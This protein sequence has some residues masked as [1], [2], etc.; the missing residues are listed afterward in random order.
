MQHFYD[1]YP[2]QQ[3]DRPWLVIGKGPT[4]DRRGEFDLGQYRLL[5]I[6]HVPRDLPVEVSH[7]IDIDVIVDCGDAIE[8]NARFVVLPWMPHV[9][10]AVGNTTLAQYCQDIPVLRRMDAEGRV[11]WYD[12]VTAPV[13]H[14]G[15]RSVDAT[16][17]SAEAA[18]SLLANSGAKKIRTLGVDGGDAYSGAFD[19]LR[20][21]TRLNNGHTSYDLQ[22]AGI[23]KTIF[24]TGIDFSPITELSP[25]KIYVGAEV[26]QRLAV[27]VLDYSIRRHAS[28]ST[29]LVSLHECGIQFKLP[30]KLENRPRTPFSFHRFAIPGLNGFKGK[31]IY[32]DSDMM[33]FQDIRKLWSMPFNGADLLAVGAVDDPSRR[34]QFSV[35]LLNCET[36]KW[37]IPEIVERLDRGELTYETLMYDM[38][39]AP[40]ISPSISR[41]W[42]SLEHYEKGNTCLLHYTDMKRQPW[43]WTRN[44]LGYLWIDYLRD[45]IRDG[46]ISRE[47]VQEDIERGWV[48]PSLLWEMDRG[49]DL[50]SYPG[51]LLAPVARYLDRDFVAPWKSLVLPK[52]S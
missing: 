25:V 2:L 46:F 51:R 28:I 41:H 26:E 7:I 10:N 5:G 50:A 30:E 1:W 9:K 15:R 6:N 3:D 34:P 37:S 52:A 11:L 17:F 45:A 19:D 43:A 27:R 48:R 47:E 13:K 40:R 4:F 49:I 22:F 21:V 33:V 39:V 8:K 32:V 14:D 44:E 18:I 42:N 36:L 24:R 31:A 12:L 20:N 38:C 35:M 16:F 29:E 23:A